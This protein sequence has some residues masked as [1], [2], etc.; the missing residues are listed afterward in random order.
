MFSQKTDG[1]QIWSSCQKDHDQYLQNAW[2]MSR[3][4][5]KQRNHFIVFG[6]R[7]EEFLFE[8]RHHLTSIWIIIEWH[9]TKILNSTA[10]FPFSACNCGDDSL[11]SILCEGQETLD[12]GAGNKTSTTMIHRQIS[13]EIR[14][15]LCDSKTRG[16]ERQAISY[17]LFVFLLQN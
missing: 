11:Q 17:G 5:A 3:I 1:V 8:N 16:H 14:G 9:L 12:T 4:F 15:W 10:T 13:P 2:W 7:G 6:E